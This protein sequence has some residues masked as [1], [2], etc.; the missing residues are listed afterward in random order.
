MA[1]YCSAREVTQEGRLI[2]R[3]NAA[4]RVFH[5]VPARREAPSRMGIN[6]RD[7]NNKRLRFPG[8]FPA[9]ARFVEAR[10]RQQQVLGT[11]LRLVFGEDQ[12]AF[13]YVLQFANISGP[14]MR[15]QQLQCQ[16]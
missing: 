9:L 8:F 14:G 11:N 15:F 4:R 10:L 16:G 13:D 3:R 12:R 2:S 6:S 7:K 1:T 5:R